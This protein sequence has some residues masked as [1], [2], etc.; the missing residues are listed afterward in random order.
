MSSKF[1][2]HPIPILR[3]SICKA[4]HGSCWPPWP[5]DEPLICQAYLILVDLDPEDPIAGAGY[6]AL[7]KIDTA[8]TWAG[9]SPPAATRVGALITAAAPP[10]RW[11]VTATLYPPGHAPASWFWLNVHIDPTRPFDTGLLRNVVL[12]NL[13]YQNVRITS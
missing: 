9:I 13:D 11:N 12:P 1:N 4:P 5:I 3:P 6:A 7:P 2:R 10:N 8:P